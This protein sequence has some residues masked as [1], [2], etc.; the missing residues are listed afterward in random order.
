[1]FHR[2]L[3]LSATLAASTTALGGVTFTGPPSKLTESPRIPL[4]ANVR[5]LLQSGRPPGLHDR[6]ADP[7]LLL[8]G[9]PL[10]NVSGEISVT[11]V[12]WIAEDGQ[13]AVQRLPTPA[14]LLTHALVAPP[15]EWVELELTLSAPPWV[16]ATTADGEI[17]DLDLPA[18][19]W[20]VALEH[21][22]QPGDA[23]RL[24]LDLTDAALSRPDDPTTAARALDGALIRVLET[25]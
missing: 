25:P 19:S 3:L 21:P 22:S 2:T 17:L 20:S 6:G 12:Q 16:R 1:M 11:A 10:M 15:G 18:A 14:N 13:R 7:S 24:E 8:D 5:P 9:A 23:L 4:A